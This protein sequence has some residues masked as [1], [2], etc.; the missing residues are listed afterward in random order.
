MHR[1]EKGGTKWQGA[2]SCTALCRAMVVLLILWSLN[3]TT[4]LWKHGSDENDEEFVQF[5]KKKENT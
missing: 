4:P 3:D 1:M 5:S 2:G